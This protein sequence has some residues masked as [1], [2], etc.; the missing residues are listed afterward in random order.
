MRQI[1]LGMALLLMLFLTGSCSRAPE[2]V[3]RPDHLEFYEL[4]S[5]ADLIVVVLLR[6]NRRSGEGVATTLRI[7]CLCN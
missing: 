3:P 5:R 2:L 6:R 4:I 1:D 7:P